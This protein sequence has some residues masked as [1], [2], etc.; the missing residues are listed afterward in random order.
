MYSY[1]ADIHM[2]IMKV[3]FHY[4]SIIYFLTVILSVIRYV[5]K[6]LYS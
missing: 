4:Q 6:I 2:L 1:T 5:F 3:L